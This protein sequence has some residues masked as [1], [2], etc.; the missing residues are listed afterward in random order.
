MRW[1]YV[2]TMMSENNNLEREKKKNQHPTNTFLSMAFLA[3]RVVDLDFS[4][5]VHVVNAGPN[6]IIPTS[7]LAVR[8]SFF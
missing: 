5:D 8:S 4:M 6:E 1:N 7:I 2:D 3:A